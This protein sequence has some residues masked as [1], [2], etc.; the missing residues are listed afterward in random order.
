MSA[1]AVGPT[2]VA[3]VAVADW[4]AVGAGAEEDAV[5]D[6]SSVVGLCTGC[7]GSTILSDSKKNSTRSGVGP[8]LRKPASFCRNTINRC[9]FDLRMQLIGS[10]RN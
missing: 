3:A 5:G 6:G 4:V 2:L 1:D 10:N 9:A 7:A 8:Y